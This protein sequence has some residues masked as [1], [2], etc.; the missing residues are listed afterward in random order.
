M[1]QWL[2]QHKTNSQPGSHLCFSCQ[3]CPD[4]E[5]D[6]DERIHTTANMQSYTQQNIEKKLDIR[7]D[8]PSDKSFRG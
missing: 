1:L 6:K 5:E 2:T 4:L 8:I 3:H 7:S